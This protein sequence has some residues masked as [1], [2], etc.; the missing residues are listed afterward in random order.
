MRK[1]LPSIATSPPP[2]STRVLPWHFRRAPAGRGVGATA[3]PPTVMGK[4]DLATWRSASC[5]GEESSG[6][7]AAAASDARE[8]VGRRCVAL[9]AVVVGGTAGARFASTNKAAGRP[10]PRGPTRWGRHKPKSRESRGRAAGSP[11]WTGSAHRPQD[12][13]PRM[14][15][16]GPPCSPTPAFVL[17]V[18]RRTPCFLL[19][20]LAYLCSATVCFSFM[21]E[22]APS[23]A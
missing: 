11:P 16:R 9:E 2:S 1:H 19:P 14:K 6:V 21:V 17:T 5:S 18:V 12:S 20:V 13:P 8:D 23:K 15:L 3:A 7:W 4:A 22:Y 10:R